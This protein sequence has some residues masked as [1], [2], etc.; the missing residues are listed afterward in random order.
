MVWCGGAGLSSGNLA[1]WVRTVRLSL[2]KKKKKEKN[3]SIMALCELK[4]NSEATVSVKMITLFIWVLLQN[5]MSWAVER[6]N[7]FKLV[8]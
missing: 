3:L 6:R 8:T 1:R 2:Q 5:S 7:L 4:V